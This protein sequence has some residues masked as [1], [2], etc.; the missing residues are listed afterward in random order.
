MLD[1]PCE[2]AIISKA[3]QKNVANPNRSRKHFH[4]ILDDFFRD[5][6]FQDRVL[7][8][9]GPGHYDFGVLTG[10]KGAIGW[11]I[12]YDPAVLE[13]GKHKGFNVLDINL[14][15]LHHHEIDCTFDGI[16]CKFSWNAF[17]SSFRNDDAVHRNAVEKIGRLAKDDA[18]IWIAPWNGASSAEELSD[19]RIMEVLDLQIRLFEEIGC[20]CTHL[21]EDATI[22]Y[23]VHG[24]VENNVLFTRNL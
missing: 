14:E 19:H 5:V 2:I 20:E 18:W 15:K 22:R 7:L 21:D 16:F 3:R 10:E 9:L 13:L 11:G 23:G 24:I 6:E 17:W 12:D 8:D 4:S 1:D